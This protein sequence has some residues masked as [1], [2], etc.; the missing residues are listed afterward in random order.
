M[1][2]RLCPSQKQACSPLSGV[3]ISESSP[4]VDEQLVEP[5]T[6]EEMV[7]GVRMEVLPSCPGRA[8]MRASLSYVIDASL[9]QATSWR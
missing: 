3:T 5:G 4:A 7:R 2:S 9:R 1:T 6:R 8:D